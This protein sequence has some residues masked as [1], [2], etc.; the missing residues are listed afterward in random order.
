[1]NTF[2][3][4]TKKIDVIVTFTFNKTFNVPAHWDGDQIDEYVHY[5]MSLDPFYESTPDDI[6]LYWKMHKERKNA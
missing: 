5:G 3:T 2:K 1:M 6:E 4:S